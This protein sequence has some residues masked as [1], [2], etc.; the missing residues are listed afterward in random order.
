M[1]VRVAIVDLR[2]DGLLPFRFDQGQFRLTICIDSLPLVEGEYS[3]GLA[4]GTAIQGDNLLDLQELVISARQ[5][6]TTVSYPANVRG[7][8]E[9]NGHACATASDL[10]SSQI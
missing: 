3:L 5:S 9:L 8:I 10:Q 6:D 2:R 7:L 4:V 1:G